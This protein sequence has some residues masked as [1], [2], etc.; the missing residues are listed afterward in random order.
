M[1]SLVKTVSMKGAIVRICVFLFML[2][3]LVPSQVAS[4]EVGEKYAQLKKEYSSFF[5]NMNNTAGEENI[6]KGKRLLSLTE[7]LRSLSDDRKQVVDSMREITIITMLDFYSQ[8]RSYDT[9]AYY[10]GLIKKEVKNNVNRAIAMATNAA[11]IST[12]IPISVR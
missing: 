8:K 3:V 5:I 9:L 11:T 10:E 6:S 2:F 12:P 4:Q 7:S 1:L